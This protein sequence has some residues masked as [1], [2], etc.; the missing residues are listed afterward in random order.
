MPTFFV[1]FCPLSGE[2]GRGGKRIGKALEENDAREKIKAHLRDSSHH[3]GKH[4]EDDIEL[5]ANAAD[6]MSEEG[7]DEEKEKGKGKKRAEP[8][9]S[10]KGKGKWVEP[11]DSWSSAWVE[12]A[13]ASSSSTVM[14]RVNVRMADKKK[15]DLMAAVARCEA[16]ARQAGRMARAAA[17]AFEAE[18]SVLHESMEAIGDMLG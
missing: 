14:A 13:P 15:E 16:A 10:G 4:S 12:P 1:C 11:A 8:Y 3:Y 5:M 18:A 9:Y 6:L 2:R 7:W 17:G